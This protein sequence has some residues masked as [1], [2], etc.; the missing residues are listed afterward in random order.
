[1]MDGL[2]ERV[3]FREMMWQC[4]VRIVFLTWFSKCVEIY[5]TGCHSEKINEWQIIKQCPASFRQGMMSVIYFRA[6]GNGSFY[7]STSSH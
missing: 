7:S 2:N 5:T 6:S 4:A 1:M 3:I